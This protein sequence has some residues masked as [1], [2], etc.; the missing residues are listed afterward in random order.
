MNGNH[1][2][3]KEALETSVSPSTTEDTLR[4]RPSLS[5]EMEVREVSRLPSLQTMRT[6]LLLFTSHLVN[7]IW[8]WHP[9]LTKTPGLNNTKGHFGV[10]FHNGGCEGCGQVRKQ[11]LCSPISSMSSWNPHNRPEDRHW[12]LIYLRTGI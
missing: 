6:E 12:I 11:T 7:G 8:L 3:M 4:R 10:R 5:L 9:E 1:S 2:L